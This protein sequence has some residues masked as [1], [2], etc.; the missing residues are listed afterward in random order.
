[1][2]GTQSLQQSYTACQIGN[3]YRLLMV[4]CCKLQILNKTAEFL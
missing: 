2:T 3:D 4:N 1:M